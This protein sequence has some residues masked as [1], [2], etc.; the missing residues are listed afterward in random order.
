MVG[1]RQHALGAGAYALTSPE[2]VDFDLA[3]RDPHSRPG[4]D[5]FHPATT[6]YLR[7]AM[8]SSS[9]C[10]PQRDTPKHPGWLRVTR[11]SMPRPHV[12]T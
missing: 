8:D 11:T 10:N 9:G 3:T 2:G 5:D 1:H 6:V 7:M 12:P 4:S